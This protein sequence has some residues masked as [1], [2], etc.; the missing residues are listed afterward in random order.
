MAAMLPRGTCPPHLEY[1]M[2]WGVEGIYT[3]AHPAPI[4]YRT[5]VSEQHPWESWLCQDLFPHPEP[6]P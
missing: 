5:L 3:A 6:V 1:H 4:E 2:G